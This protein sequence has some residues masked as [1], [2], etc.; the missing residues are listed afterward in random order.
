MADSLICTTEAETPGNGYLDPSMTASNGS[1]SLRRIEFHLARKPFSGISKGRGNFQLETLNSTETQRPGANPGLSSALNGK[2]SDRSDI[3]ENG[4]DPE[5]SFTITFQRIG[6]GL[7]NLGNTCFLNSV[8]QCLTYTEP[9]AAYLQRSKHQNSCHIAGFC[10]LC[11][12]QKHVSRALQS[13]GRILAPKDLVSNLR[14]ISRNFRNF[15]QE[16]AHEYMVNLLE[17]MHKCCLPSGV[18]S[19]SPNAYERSLVHKIFGGRLR[20]EVKCMQCSYSSHKFDPFLDLSLEIAKAE[21]LQKALMNFTTAEQLDGGERQYQC[22]QCKQKVRALKRLTVHK[23][24]YVLTIHLKRFRSYDPGK[25]IDTKVRFGPSLDLKPFV[26]GFYEGDLKYTLYGVLVHAGWSTRSGHY[27]CF[28]RTSKGMW[29]SLDDNRVV[30][31]SEK[32]VLE[33][34]AYILFYVRVRNTAPRKSVDAVQKENLVAKVMRNSVFSTSNEGSKGAVQHG[35]LERGFGCVDTPHASTQSDAFNAGSSKVISL[36]EASVQKDNAPMAA[37]CTVLKKCP[38][39]ESSLEELSVL[40]PEIGECLPP[41]V[42]SVQSIRV[43]PSLDNTLVAETAAITNDF[44][45]DWNSKKGS[46]VLVAVPPKCNGHQN[47]ATDKLVT[48]HISP[49]INIV[50][51]SVLGIASSDKIGPSRSSDQKR[52]DGQFGGISIVSATGGDPPIAKTGDGSP[53]LSVELSSQSIAVEPTFRTKDHKPHRK[54]KKK[55]K[56][57]VAIGHLQPNRKSKKVSRSIELW[58]SFFFKASTSLRKKK[59]L[60]R[61]KW[62]SLEKNNLAQGNL[63]T[64]TDMGPSTSEITQTISPISTHSRKRVRPGSKS[65]YRDHGLKRVI[66]SNGGSLMDLTTGQF[67]QKTCRNRDVI[68]TDKQPEKRPNSDLGKE[69]QCDAR[70]HGTLKDG[71]RLPMQNGLM[72][73]LTRGPERVTDVATEKWPEKSSRSGSAENRCDAREPDSLK[74]GKNVGMNNGLMGMLTR[75]LEETTV[76]QWDGIDLPVSQK[77]ESNTSESMRI[78]YIPDE[79]DEE[80]DR[81]KRKKV[82]QSK[83]KFDGS[84]PFQIFATQKAQIKKGRMDRLSS[85]NQPFRI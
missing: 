80:Y 38:E 49:T 47:P 65:S 30:Q 72:G 33:Q 14:C 35:P 70:E 37:E 53:K 57:Q 71:K 19:E 32:T 39:L 6:A 17:S 8:L 73:V 26:S 46:S 1:I 2:K 56:C 43:T 10:A 58:S 34:K 61:S 22:Q 44:N 24:P 5:L 66:N 16:D 21:S 59:K 54:S 3:F 42:P 85:A 28:V 52:S 41:S 82:R 13:S 25:K 83:N 81:G 29:Y 60:K 69:N 78:G 62:R 45:K 18:P 76:A 48:D 68:A 23:A 67:T 7:E 20:S 11:A 15:R 36:K 74:D 64:E 12:I 50:S 63:T 4:L 55:V 84:N 79:W 77:I 51:K 31:V 27:Y 9:L 75:G 40:N